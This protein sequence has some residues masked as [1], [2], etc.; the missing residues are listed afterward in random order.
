VVT[1]IGD[2]FVRRVLQPKGQVKV[3]GVGKE[4]V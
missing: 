3:E 1:V 4:L 2:E